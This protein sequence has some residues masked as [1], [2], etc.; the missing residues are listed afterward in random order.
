MQEI[1]ELLREYDRAR[2]YTDG[3]WRD[4]TRTS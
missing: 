1:G 3:L 2:A 4:L